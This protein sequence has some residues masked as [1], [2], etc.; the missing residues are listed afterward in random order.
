MQALAQA[1]PARVIKMEIKLQRGFT[2]AE[3]TVVLFIIGVLASLLTP[4]IMKRME[5]AKIE[6]SIAQATNVLQY[7]EMARR[8]VL[9]T[10]IDTKL[11]A[12]HQYATIPSWAET[13]VLEAQIGAGISI[14][15]L[16]PFG[17]PILV[18][19]DSRRCYV[20]I[21]IGFLLNNAAGYTT[22]TVNG[23]TRII[24][25]ARPK[26]GSSVDWVIKQKKLLN[27]EITR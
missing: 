7:C 23:K 6:S 20:G 11:T 8:N 3:I 21:D 27:S 4:P 25:S 17:N 10:S 1:M 13:D 18:K 14:A 22:Q 12:T 16:N 19:N 26:L 24:I 5:T 2:L 9:A 15:R